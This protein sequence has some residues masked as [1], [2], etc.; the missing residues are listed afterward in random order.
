MAAHRW[1]RC[2][3]Y[4]L[5]KVG[6][7]RKYCNASNLKQRV[8]RYEARQPV[9]TFQEVLPAAHEKRAERGIYFM[10]YA[11]SPPHF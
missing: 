1:L 8:P 7:Y 2:S 10:G 11:M 5:A 9:P 4:G 6:K 3:G